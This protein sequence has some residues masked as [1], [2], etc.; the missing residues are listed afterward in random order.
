MTEPVQ[1]HGARRLK[2]GSPVQS[3]SWFEPGQTGPCCY[4][5]VCVWMS[6]ELGIASHWT[7][8][9]INVMQTYSSEVAVLAA[10]HSVTLPQGQTH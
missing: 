8:S 4:V 7:A 3:L 9:Q 2:S 10:E 1:S 6:V 5:H